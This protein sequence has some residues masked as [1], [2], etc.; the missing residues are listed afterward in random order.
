MKKTDRPSRSRFAGASLIEVLVA[1]AVLSTGTLALLSLQ[2]LQTAH[3][4]QENTRSAAWEAAHDAVEQHVAS[5]FGLS[6]RPA[7]PRNTAHVE[8][9]AEDQLGLINVRAWQPWTDMHQST[10]QAQAQRWALP[11]S[12]AL[13]DDAS[14]IALAHRVPSRWPVLAAVVTAP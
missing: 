11:P 1:S 2:G 6:P 9:T 10:H 5:L 13:V 4:R 3:V 12:P 7:N 14:R 8:H